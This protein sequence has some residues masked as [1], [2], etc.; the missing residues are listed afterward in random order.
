MTQDNLATHDDS[1][2]VT[3]TRAEYKRIL[4]LTT[5]K[6]INTAPRDKAILVNGDSGWI[7]A[8]FSSNFNEF[9]TNDEFSVHKPTHWLPLPTLPI[10]ESRF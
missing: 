7:E 2:T 9:M 10:K 6:S 1:D 5:P 4:G 8:E 3:I